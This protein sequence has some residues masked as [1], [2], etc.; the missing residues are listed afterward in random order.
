MI[1]YRIVTES[2]SLRVP[3]KLLRTR[4]VCPMDMFSN[5]QHRPEDP[6]LK[7]IVYLFHKGRVELSSFRS[8]TGPREGPEEEEE[9]PAEDTGGTSSIGEGEGIVVEKAGD[10]VD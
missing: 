2:K 5:L 6:F 4:R 3:K 8:S 9:A 7:L 10:E 1:T